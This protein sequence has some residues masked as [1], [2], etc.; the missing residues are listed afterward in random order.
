MINM[1]IICL[2]LYTQ[3]TSNNSYFTPCIFNALRSKAFQQSNANFF[4][5][6]YGA[7][8]SIS[9]VRREFFFLSLRTQQKLS[10]S[11]AMTSR[12]ANQRIFVQTQDENIENELVPLVF[13]IF[14]GSFS[15]STRSPKK[16]RFSM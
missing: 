9:V 13:L 15:S 6:L 11:I 5:F 1:V 10:F 14:R 2:H 16:G 3:K 8:Q 12:T 7:K 4:S